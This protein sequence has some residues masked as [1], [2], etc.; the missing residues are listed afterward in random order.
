MC[1]HISLK[2]SHSHPATDATGHPNICLNVP[3]SILTGSQ[4]EVL[5]MALG[6]S[7]SL[8]GLLVD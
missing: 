8:H 4:V 5:P 2:N 3:T 7:D 1:S 6:P